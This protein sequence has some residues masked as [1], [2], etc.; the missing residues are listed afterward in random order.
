MSRR[1][2][3]TEEELYFADTDR[4][5]DEGYRMA[6]MGDFSLMDDAR[7]SDGRH[8]NHVIDQYDASVEPRDFPGRHLPKG[9]T[10]PTD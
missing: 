1:S 6:A 8:L 10:L 4:R 3:P 7:T 5:L 2:K 9:R